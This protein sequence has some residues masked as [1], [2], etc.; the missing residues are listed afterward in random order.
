MIHGID[1]WID[2]IHG[3]DLWSDEAGMNPKELHALL[4]QHGRRFSALW[5]EVHGL[6]RRDAVRSEDFNGAPQEVL[7][8]VDDVAPGL[9]GKA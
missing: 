8:A 5:L 4:L 9:L 7:W 3:I 2:M 1:L 6:L